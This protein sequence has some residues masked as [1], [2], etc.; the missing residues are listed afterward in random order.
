[1][2]KMKLVRLYDDY[3]EEVKKSLRLW[4]S[5]ERDAEFIQHTVST[6]EPRLDHIFPIDRPLL[7]SAWMT[8]NEF[9]LAN[10]ARQGENVIL[11]TKWGGTY[12]MPSMN[13]V[14]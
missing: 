12:T 4:F 5:G 14:T 8:I 13:A 6:E 11:A 7:R 9:L 1:M 3:P 10:G 2:K